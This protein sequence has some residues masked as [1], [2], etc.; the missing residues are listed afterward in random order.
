MCVLDSCQL[1]HYGRFLA[2]PTILAAGIEENMGGVG[3]VFWDC[4]DVVVTATAARALE[5]MLNI[6]D[7]TLEAKQPEHLEW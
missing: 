2:R 7:A 6:H 3:G 5:M 1:V 4:Y